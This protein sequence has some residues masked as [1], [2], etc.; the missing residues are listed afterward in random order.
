[1][2]YFT[3]QSY[4]EAYTPKHTYT[5]AGKCLTSGKNISVTVEADDLYA[6][7]QGAHIQDA[8]P[9]LTPD[10]REWMMSGMFEFPSFEE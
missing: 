8:F 1:M 2:P 6:Y 9:Y 5:F 4:T 10:E 7:N 3:N